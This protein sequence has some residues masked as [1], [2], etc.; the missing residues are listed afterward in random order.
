M[1][2]GF[3]SRKARAL[4]VDDSSMAVQM[5]RFMLQQCG[6]EDITEAGD[7]LEALEKF[8]GSLEKETP[9]SLVFLD[10]VMPLLE[11]QEALRQMRVMELNAGVAADN[12]AVI[13][14]AT[15]L[16]S[17]DEMLDALNDSDY[18]DYLVKPYDV[19]DIRRMLVKYNFTS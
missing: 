18:T 16:D 19:K 4:I 7:G 17:S 6:V 5:M 13:I 8:H 11:G 3:M 9:Y 10:V 2:E 12:A 1:G 15:A 14:M